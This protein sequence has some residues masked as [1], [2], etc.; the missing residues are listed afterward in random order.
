MKMK[1]MFSALFELLL[2]TDPRNIKLQKARARA[3][4]KPM[5]ASF[6]G[7]ISYGKPKLG[8]RKAQS[9]ARHKEIQRRKRRNAR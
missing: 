5:T 6:V 7:F 9:V 4:L 8:W 2:S 3:G 1:S